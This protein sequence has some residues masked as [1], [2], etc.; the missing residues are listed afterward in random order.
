MTTKTA[1]N[2]I[3]TATKEMK[4]ILLAAVLLAGTMAVAMAQAVIVQQNDEQ[5]CMEMQIAENEFAGNNNS[6][7]LTVFYSDGSKASSVKVTTVVSGGIGCMC[8]RVFY[9]DY[10]GVV[11][12][13]WSEGCYLKK[14]YVE[15]NG[16]DADY[17]KNDGK[18]SL[19]LN[20]K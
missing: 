13:S 4:K 10:K 9:T 2:R 6:C 1:G 11:T 17:F 8:G 18:Y 19:T 7:T 20:T 12:L 5:E 16:Y 3:K 14:V 15:G